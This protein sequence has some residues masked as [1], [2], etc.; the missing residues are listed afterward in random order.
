MNEGRLSVF[1]D[2]IEDGGWERFEGSVKE[3]GKEVGGCP[4]VVVVGLDMSLSDTE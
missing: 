4:R 1:E 3:T 2:T